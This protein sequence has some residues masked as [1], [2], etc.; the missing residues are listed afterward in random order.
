MCALKSRAHRAP[1]GAASSTHV[2]VVLCRTDLHS[3]GRSLRASVPRAPLLSSTTSAAA[4]TARRPSALAS[5]RASGSAAP[6][7]RLPLR[8]LA[9]GLAAAARSLSGEGISSCHCLEWRHNELSARATVRC[10]RASRSADARLS[11]VDLADG[12]AATDPREHAAREYA[13]Y[14]ADLLQQ[15]TETA[16][17]EGELDNKKERGDHKNPTL[18]RKAAQARSR[19]MT[20]SDMRMPMYL[21]VPL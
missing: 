20:T 1:S 13:A 3:R 12:H 15:G 4:S 10:A 5:K 11:F 6:G 19:Q 21:P 7:P 14:V 17:R 16:K 8:L 9:L 18:A 2:Q